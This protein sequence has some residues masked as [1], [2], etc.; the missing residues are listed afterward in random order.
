MET[1]QPFTCPQCH[2]GNAAVIGK[3]RQQGGFHN[4]GLDRKAGY[5]VRHY[6][7]KIAIVAQ[8]ARDSLQLPFR[9]KGLVHKL[10]IGILL[11]G[12]G[13]GI[14]SAFARPVNLDGYTLTAFGKINANVINKMIILRGVANNP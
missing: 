3:A 1:P 8:N 2:K 9:R 11:P 13:F 7:A 5:F 14:A 10:E 12:H 6:G 4:D